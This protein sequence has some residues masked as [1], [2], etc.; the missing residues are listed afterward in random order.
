MMMMSMMRVSGFGDLKSFAGGGI[1]IKTQGLTQ[2]NR[3]SPAGWAVISIYVLGAHGKKEH[4][5]K[6]HCQ[7]YKRLKGVVVGVVVGVYHK[8]VGR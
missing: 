3:T 4:G 2:G 6:L 8:I 5:A 1:S 7:Y